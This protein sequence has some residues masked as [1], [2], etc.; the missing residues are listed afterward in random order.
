VEVGKVDDEAED[1]LSVKISS[2]RFLPVAPTETTEDGTGMAAIL[3]QQMLDTG[4]TRAIF[5][6]NARQQQAVV[7]STT[8]K[9]HCFRPPRVIVVC[10]TRSI[11]AMSTNIY[12]F[13]RSADEYTTLEAKKSS[14]IKIN[15]GIIFSLFFLNHFYWFL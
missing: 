14:H 1:K 7:V 5:F 13:D 9:M 15:E 6:V 8:T 11:I 4:V 10:Y 2:P 3:S 12:D